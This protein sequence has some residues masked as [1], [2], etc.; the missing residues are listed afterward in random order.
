MYKST[1][2]G[3]TMAKKVEAK[4]AAKKTTKPVAKKKK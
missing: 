2:K 1:E 4:A 3:G